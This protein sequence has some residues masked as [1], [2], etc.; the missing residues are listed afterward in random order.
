MAHPLVICVLVGLP[1]SGK[2]TFAR[3]AIV[4]PFRKLVFSYDEVEIKDN[5]YKNFRMKARDRLEKL[6]LDESR[7]QTV[8]I[9]DDIMTYRSMRYEIFCIARKHNSGFCQVY[10]NTKVDTCILR[11]IDRGSTEITAE[12]IKDQANRLEVPGSSNSLMDKFVM[13]VEDNRYDPEEFLQL[14]QNAGHELPSLLEKSPSQPQDQS[15]VHKIDLILR[16]HIGTCISQAE[17]PE[18]KRHLAQDMN[19]RRH[20]LLKDIRNKNIIFNEPFDDVINYL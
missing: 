3:N 11:N 6:I 4:D 1:G 5:N 2:S 14:I 17:S 7:E 8:I 20:E 9:V 15:V 12:M 10:M 13:A 18:A 19:S 16:K